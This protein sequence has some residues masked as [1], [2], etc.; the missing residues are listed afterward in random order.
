MLLN[1]DKDLIHGTISKGD[2]Q[3]DGQ[4]E[5]KPIDPEYDRRFPHE[6]TNS[7]QQQFFDRMIPLHPGF[8]DELFRRHFRSILQAATAGSTIIQALRRGPAIYRRASGPGLHG[9]LGSLPWRDWRS[10]P[11]P[12]GRLNLVENR[13]GVLLEIVLGNIGGA[14][15]F[16]I[17]MRYCFNFLL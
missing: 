17:E 10:M 15:C 14:P 5:R 13:V 12:R 16:G 3:S 4:Q 9:E 1:V 8:M 11:F 7:H 2:S 6:L